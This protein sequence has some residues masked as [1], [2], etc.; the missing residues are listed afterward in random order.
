MSNQLKD[1]KSPYLLQHA[2]NPV[3]WY[4]WCSQA[5]ETARQEEKPIF[6][7]IGYSTCHWCHVMAHESFE[8]EEIARIL[9]RSFV[10]I[11]VDREERPDI[12]AVYMTVCQAMTGSGG[13][14]LTILMTPKQNPFY[15]GTY[16]PRHSRYGY[17]G[18]SELLLRV[19]K[20]WQEQREKLEQ[21]GKE[22][23]SWLKSPRTPSGAEPSLELV[24]R[25]AEELFRTFDSRWGGFGRAPKFPT[26]HNLTFLL[27]Y[28]QKE[29]SEKAMQIVTK[30]LECMARGG[31]YDQIGGGFSRYSTDEQWLIPHFEKMLY[32][33]ALLIDVYAQ[34]YQ[35]TG[36]ALFLSVVRETVSYV[37][38]E[39]PGAE[40]GF[41]CGQ[42]ADSEGV[43]GKYYMLT[44][45]EVFKVLNEK[46]A[47]DFC[48]FFD[49]TKEGTFEGKNIPN[50]LRQPDRKDRRMEM[51][52]RQIYH[53]RLTRTSL[54]RDD[55]ILTAWNSLMIVALAKASFLCREPA[56]LKDAVKAQQFV[57]THLTDERGRLYVRYRDKEAAF[58]GNLE[59]YAYYAW[60]LLELYQITWN[61]DFLEKAARIAKEM[62]RWF[63]DSRQGGF[64]LYASDSEQLISRPKETWDGALPSGNSVAAHIFSLLS[65][66]TGEEIWQKERDRTMQYLAEEAATSPSGHSFALFSMCSL[67]YPSAQL[68]CASAEARMPQKLQ[69][70]LCQNSLPGL[71]VLLLT[72]ENKEQLTRIAPF[73]AHY[74]IP[75]RGVRYYLCQGHGCSAGSEDF[76]KLAGSLKVSLFGSS[77]TP[78]ASDGSNP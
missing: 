27:C 54:H 17:L 47:E 60:A 5:F 77:G 14:P 41:C 65:D 2:E 34:A 3:F 52:C 31:I 78:G 56:W 19:E 12:D 11:K 43:E 16:L 74:P 9:N 71:T 24:R 76:Q 37:L 72:P 23:S 36:N 6:L 63:S 70:F 67:L 38:R 33:N 4:P 30:T 18:L 8:N 32:D 28:A 64:Y 42:D 44:K 20:L 66:L 40:G 45:E 73:T 69:D 22:I 57:E 25:G 55:K 21:T 75:D 29:Q 35:V 51:L 1:Q 39:L 61:A 49:I 13:W 58:S 48:R 46:D 26:P 59:D 7:S 10:S 50:L 62:I 68:L 53:Y 15:A